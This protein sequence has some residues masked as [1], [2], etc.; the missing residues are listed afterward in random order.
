[1]TAHQRTVLKGR[2]VSKY[3]HFA[4]AVRGL[5]DEHDVAEELTLI[6][7]TISK[8]RIF[9]VRR[10]SPIRESSFSDKEWSSI[11]R[12]DIQ[13]G[14]NTDPDIL[15]IFYVT[16]NRMLVHLERIAPVLFQ[17]MPAIKPKLHSGKFKQIVQW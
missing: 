1:M 2:G 9:A 8:K 16:E 10:V 14:P 5:S 17:I 15:I 13:R 7:S 6:V 11:R 4:F 3:N 12:R